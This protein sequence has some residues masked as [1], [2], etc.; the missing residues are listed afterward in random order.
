MSSRLTGECCFQPCTNN[1]Q[2]LHHKCIICKRFIHILCCC[3]NDIPLIEGE[4]EYRCLPCYTISLA[5]KPATLAVAEPTSKSL[6]K[7]EV[8]K[9]KAHIDLS[10]STNPTTTQDQVHGKTIEDDSLLCNEN[11]EELFKIG[12]TFE[13]IDLL[14]ESLQKYASKNAFQISSGS[15]RFHC[16]RGYATKYDSNR[17]RFKDTQ[18]M[19][20]RV[21]LLKCGCEW[22]VSY[23]SLKNG[24]VMIT[25]HFLTH[26]NGCEPTMKQKLSLV[27][28]STKPKDLD[29]KLVCELLHW[30]RVMKKRL[31]TSV[32]RAILKQSFPNTMHLSNMFLINVRNK[33]ESLN[34]D[35]TKISDTYSQVDEFLLPTQWMSELNDCLDEELSPFIKDLDH[36]IELLEDVD[37][38]ETFKLERMLKTIAEKDKTFLYKMGVNEND[39]FTGCCWQTGVMRGNYELYG[40]YLSLD[41]M[42]RELNTHH[43][44]YV[45]GT[46][47]NDM[48]ESQ[49]CIE[50]LAIGE[51]KDTYRFMLNSLIEFSPGLNPTDVFVVTSDAFLDQGFINEFYPTAN[52]LID[53]YHLIEAIKKEV[54]LTRWNKYQPLIY[55]MINAKSSATFDVALES[56]Q[57]LHAGD[58]T[59]TSYFEGK[60]NDRS[61]FVQYER[62]K[63]FGNMGLLGSTMSEQNN[64]SVLAFIED[65]TSSRCVVELV[66]SLLRRQ[67]MKELKTNARLQNQ[68]LFM[69]NEARMAKDTWR[70]EAASK[71]GQ[72]SYQK[73]ISEVQKSQDYV[74][75]E[76]EGFFVVRRIN[77]DAQPRRFLAESTRCVCTFR[78][79]HLMPC[80]HEIALSKFCGIPIFNIVTFH[81][82]HHQ[83]SGCYVS[84]IMPDMDDD[85]SL[86]RFE[87]DNTKENELSETSDEEGDEEK[88]TL[89]TFKASNLLSNRIRNLTFGDI[90]T[91]STEV[92]NILMKVQGNELAKLY[93]GFNAKIID[94]FHDKEGADNTWEITEISKYCS[95]FLNC[96]SESLTGRKILSR[97]RKRSRIEKLSQSNPPKEKSCTLCGQNFSTGHHTARNC[98]NRKASK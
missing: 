25:N 70:K 18:P 74:V 90:I 13:N 28:K 98:P 53:R 19:R 32:I 12:S 64:S 59:L 21:S 35:D 39:K 57:L 81:K 9:F 78:I 38:L 2:E 50:C 89:D 5:A 14:R 58:N 15:R 55:E 71:L 75:N 88:E 46:V 27:T 56:I 72:Y 29:P 51:R 8:V 68:V 52:F 91:S 79:G 30:R 7:P 33:I 10:D 54:T 16:Y 1:T 62:E 26:T 95:S 96:M 83:R 3:D 17:H 42:R 73:F 36:I 67:N 31:P 93:V 60:S 76:S 40:H 23:T 80:A 61:T 85:T 6:R 92:A 22:N 34:V 87:A 20:N 94:L 48:N 69:M 45:A 24:L 63:F 82:R 4:D 11:P 44:C 66:T 97:K 84:R 47:R 86:Q 49:V 41:A 43:W 77:S 37:E 65:L